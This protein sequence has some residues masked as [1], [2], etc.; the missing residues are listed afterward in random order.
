MRNLTVTS[1]MLLLFISLVFNINARGKE[2]EIIT[3]KEIEK[4]IEDLKDKLGNMDIYVEPCSEGSLHILRDFEEEHEILIKMI[5]DK[6]GILISED[7]YFY[8][9]GDMVWIHKENTGEK[10]VHFMATVKKDGTVIKKDFIEPVTSTHT[11]APTEETFFTPTQTAE[12]TLFPAETPTYKPTSAPTS[13]PVTETPGTFKE[14]IIFSSDL[15]GTMDIYTMNLDGTN[16]HRITTGEYSEIM[17]SLSPDGTKIIYTSD[18]NKSWNLYTVNLDGTNKTAITAGP[19]DDILPLFADSETIIFQSL[20]EGL[21]QIYSLVLGPQKNLTKLTA[22]FT[23]AMHPALS[24]D[25][26]KIIFVGEKNGNVELYSMD[27]D[28]NNLEQLTQTD[29]KKAFPSVSPDGK[30]IAFTENSDGYWNI[31]TIDIAGGKEKKSENDSDS[32][33]DSLSQACMKRGGCP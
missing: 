29:S 3:A 8:S 18:E 21:P 24:P 32:H 25:R 30:Q 16:L 1:I 26:K 7:R 5:Y 22:G 13:P 19:Q 2:A 10:P 27:R 23:L 9:Q 20:R 12:P 14:R 31:Y 17:P 33:K 15:E 11:P 4:K 28:G 6:K